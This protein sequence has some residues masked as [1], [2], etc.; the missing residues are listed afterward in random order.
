MHHPRSIPAIR[1]FRVAAYLL[2]CNYLLALIA[3]GMLVHSLLSDNRQWIMAGTGLV[4][5]C[6]ILVVAQWIAACRTGCPL[7]RTPVLAPKTCMKH[8]RARTFV[9][10]HRLRVAV[11]ILFK[12]RF[13]CPYCNESTAM[14]LRETLHGPHARRHLPQNR[15]CL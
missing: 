4:I 13:R 12:C 15:R 9:G 2:A 7:C 6:M 3:A 14:K 10:S 5:L 1:R 8:R 11:A